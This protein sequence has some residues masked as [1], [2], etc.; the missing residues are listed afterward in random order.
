MS[1]QPN[2]DYRLIAKAVFDASVERYKF[3]STVQADYGKWLLV[4]ITSAHLA[5][6][7]LISRPEIP[8]Q[9]REREDCYW[10]SIVGLCLILI[11]GLITWINWSL[12]VETIGKWTDPNVLIN[13]DYWP[14]SPTGYRKAALNFT[15]Y[16]PLFLG[17]AS[18]ICIPVTA[19]HVT[20][21]LKVAT[22]IR[23]IA[24]TG[25]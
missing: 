9:I 4:T 3:V 16:A 6:I 7:Y 23:V 13:D 22:S 21:H 14:K 2:A 1:S 5:A 24:P 15:F 20:K 10:P 12:V 17:L 25:Q 11:A 19:E 18:A 8:A